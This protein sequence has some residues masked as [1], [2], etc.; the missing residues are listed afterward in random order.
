MEKKADYC[1]KLNVPYCLHIHA[2]AVHPDYQG[3]S[4]AKK[5]FE[6]CM[7]NGE[8]KHFPAVSVD[9]TNYFSVKIAEEFEMT[10]LSVVTYNEYNELIGDEIFH[11]NE[12]HTI[13]KSYVKVF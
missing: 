3:Q 9:C 10:C 5:L 2:I 7:A 1:N 11:P 8:A 13:I 6:F 12:P 4:I